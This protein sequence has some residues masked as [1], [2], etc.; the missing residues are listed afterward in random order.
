MQST[1]GRARAL[2]AAP[3]QLLSVARW[4]GTLSPRAR[5]AERGGVCVCDS[6]LRLCLFDDEALAAELE[7]RH[8]CAHIYK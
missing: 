5:H 6:R 1:A 2:V 7:L 4:T 8:V 3:K